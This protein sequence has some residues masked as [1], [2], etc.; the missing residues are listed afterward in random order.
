MNRTTVQS[1]KE[2]GQVRVSKLSYKKI[3]LDYDIPIHSDG[4]PTDMKVNIKLRYN[5]S[6]GNSLSIIYPKDKFYNS[7]SM[8]FAVEKKLLSTLYMVPS[9]QKLSVSV[10]G[11]EYSIDRIIRSINIDDKIWTR[12]YKLNRLLNC[13]N[14]SLI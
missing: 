10:E 3:Q 8:R 12:D 11:V 14:P 2:V 4:E 6:D 5:I 9:T 1:I 13:T 7:L